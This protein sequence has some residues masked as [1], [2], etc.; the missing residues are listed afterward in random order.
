MRR[1]I[2]NY[3]RLNPPTVLGPFN[4]GWCVLWITFCRSAVGPLHE[5]V[6]IA[7]F[8]RTIV[9]KVP[10]IWVRGPRR[11]F[12]RRH[13]GLDRFGPRAR[14]LIINERHRRDLAWPVTAL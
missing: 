6:D 8:Q 4:E 12:P 2:H 10:I 1:Q 3:I 13:C 14:L 5:R 7:L 11:H 9:R